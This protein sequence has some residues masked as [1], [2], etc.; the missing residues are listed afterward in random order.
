[1]I[2][3]ERLYHRI[4]WDARLDPARFVLGIDVHGPEPKR[5]AFAD[6]RP[7]G[8]IPW[9]R[10]LFFEADGELVWDRR[11]GVERLDDTTAGR[12]RVTMGC[13]RPP[14]WEPRAAVRWDGSAWARVGGEASPVP[15]SGL[16]VLTWNALWDRYDSDQIA[17]AQRWPRLLDAVLNADPELVALQEVQPALHELLLAHPEVRARWWVSH[18]LGH[19]DVGPYDLLLLGRV[20]VV[21]VGFCA[22]EAHKA[23]L[24]A[25]VATALGPVVV[26]TTHL[27]SDHRAGAAERRRAEVALLQAALDGLLHPT[28]VLGDMNTE[29]PLEL[30]ADCARVLGTGAPTFDPTANP[31]AVLASRTQRPRRIDRVFAQ[32]LAPTSVALHGTAPVDGHWLSDHYGVEVALVE[33]VGEA[34]DLEPVRRSA[35]A[36]V[37]RAH[38]AEAV[39]A[40]R[41]E[42]D[43]AVSRWPAHVNVLYGFVPEHALDAA[44]GPLGNAAR[45]VQAFDAALDGVGLFPGEPPVCWLDPGAPERW[46]TLHGAFARS[47]P[48]CARPHYTPHLTVGR[49]AGARA[50]AEA[51]GRLEVRVEELLVLTRRGGE[52]FAPRARVQLGVGAELL[53]ES[54]LELG[55]ALDVA[56]VHGRI[57]AALRSVAPGSRV[58]VVGSHRLGAAVAWSD[59]DL[60][61]VLPGDLPAGAPEALGV[62]VRRVVKAGLPGLQLVADGVDVDVIAVPAGAQ[63]ARDALSAVDDVDRLLER[64]GDRLEAFRSLLRLVKGFARVHALDT[65]AAGGLGGLAW[66]VLAALTT[67][68]A[69]R[70]EPEVLAR[71][72]FGTWAAWDWRLPVSLSGVVPAGSEGAVVVLTPSAPARSLTERVGAID[73]DRLTEA[74]YTAWEGLEAGDERAP[75]RPPPWHRRHAAWLEL[76]WDGD[77]ETGGRLRGGLRALLERLRARDLPAVAWPR[78]VGGRLLVGLGADGAGAE[79]VARGWLRR[80]GAAEVG[81]AVIDSGRVPTLR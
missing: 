32:G 34:V 19:A 47:F 31:L 40:L 57:A 62:P 61:W 50:G 20:P 33:A 37:A 67:C 38:V 30:G 64:V 75:L 46:A 5:V 39:A 15:G 78:P 17:S 11:T 58:E 56:P 41:A 16:R 76:S 60:L 12:V 48:A 77:A 63:S 2:T 45:R 65:S 6:F 13:L 27:S 74:L 36:W 21:E 81:V 52:P 8:D 7:G 72:F 14:R 25:T 10:V 66:A 55:P 80:V 3:S 53:P 69:D 28:V 59:L 35:L 68:T 4:R 18:P 9:H 24:A 70:F 23:L 44:V 49:G 26:A 29:E 42:H 71:R 54:P 79:E 22:F 51:I 73:R 43:P 1:M